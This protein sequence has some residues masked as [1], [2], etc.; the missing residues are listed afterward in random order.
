[1]KQLSSRALGVQESATL[2]IGAQ[3]KALKAAG[4]HII[5][6]SLGEP[7]FPTP[8]LVKKAAQYAIKHNFT[9]YTASGG[10]PDLKKAVC[11]KLQRDNNLSYTH[12]QILISHGAKH[13]LMNI[14]FTLL[15]KGDEV[16]IPTPYWTSYPEMVKLADGV[17]VFCET[18]AAFHLT[19][20]ALE[21]KCTKK[22]KLLL[23]NS[24]SNPTGA[25]IPKEELEKIAALCVNKNIFV[26]S[27]EVYEFFCYDS[28]THSSIASFGKE[29]YNR[30][31][32]VNSVSKTYSM[33]GWRIGYL[34]GP[35]ELVKKMDALQSQMTS[36]PNSIAQKAAVAALTSDQQCV[37]EMLHAFTL[38]RDYISKRLNAVAGLSLLPPEGAFYAFVKFSYPLS[39]SDF[40]LQLLNDGLAATVPGSAF[41]AEGYF[42]ISYATSMN[43][44]KEGCDRM[45][46]FCVR[47]SSKTP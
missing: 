20:A 19:A 42:R 18:D 3:A 22:T 34:A 33:T 45:E 38:R 44:I 39:S 13:S 30:T 26:I 31:F 9:Y 16:I 21:K 14:F 6:F 46:K 23:V 35:Q 7:D 28:H 15:N 36:C 37:Q 32:T 8:R 17:P 2:A 10:I 41:G 1:M 40:C 11:M 25:V 24:P 43:V 27:D 47:F 5:D 29:I 12:E 4:K